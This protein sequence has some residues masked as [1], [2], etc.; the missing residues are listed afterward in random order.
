MSEITIHDLSLLFPTCSGTPRGNT[1]SIALR[2]FEPQ[3]YVIATQL[4]EETT[5]HLWRPQLIVFML[6]MMQYVPNALIANFQPLALFQSP[7]GLTYPL[8]KF[9]Q[10]NCTDYS[11]NVRRH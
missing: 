5:D 6:R 11:R 10:V 3:F 7:T 8:R 1:P 2:Y 9:G 4:L